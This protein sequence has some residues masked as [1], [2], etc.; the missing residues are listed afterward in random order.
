M[1]VFGYILGSILRTLLCVCF[2]G[3][4]VVFLSLFSFD[5][6]YLFVCFCFVVVQSF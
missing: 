5:I 6:V 1:T 2:V 4:G 3:F